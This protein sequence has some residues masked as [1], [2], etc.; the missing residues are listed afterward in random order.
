[1][2]TKNIKSKLIKSSKSK[3]GTTILGWLYKL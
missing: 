1:M 3:D 2:L